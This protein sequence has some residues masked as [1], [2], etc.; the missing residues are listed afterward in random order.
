M[1]TRLATETGRAVEVH[2]ADL[3]QHDDL[4]RVEKLV[5]S[6]EDVTI[7]LNNAGVGA[8]SALVNSDVDSVGSRR[9]RS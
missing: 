5:A 8:V 9:C 3:G 4:A 6:R 7:L 1:A 2:V